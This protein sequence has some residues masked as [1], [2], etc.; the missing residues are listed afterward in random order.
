MTRRTI[1]QLWKQVDSKGTKQLHQQNDS[2]ATKQ[3]WQ[4]KNGC[5]QTAQIATTK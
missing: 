2:K 1:K 4:P 3:L 5:N